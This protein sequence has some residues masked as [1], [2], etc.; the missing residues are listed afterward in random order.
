MTWCSFSKLSKFSFSNCQNFPFPNCQKFLSK[1]SKFPFLKLSKFFF[2]NCQNSRFPNCQNSP[3]QTVKIL[4]FKKNWLECRIWFSVS[5]LKKFVDHY[6]K[7]YAIHWIVL[8]IIMRPWAINLISKIVC[9]K[10]KR[11]VNRYQFKRPRNRE[12]NIN[13]HQKNDNF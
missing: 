7:L 2:S 11:N 8:I 12:K 1:L 9:K 6:D 3:F 5:R 10:R 13:F 4:L